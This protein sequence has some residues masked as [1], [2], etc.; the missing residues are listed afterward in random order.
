VRGVK[1]VYKLPA[2]EKT[3]FVKP[4]PH[5]FIVGSRVE[6]RRFQAMGQLHA[7]C[8]APN[9]GQIRRHLAPRAVALQVA[10]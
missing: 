2:F 6:T 7:T 4:V 5:H 10:F 9:R 3:N 8:T 1:L